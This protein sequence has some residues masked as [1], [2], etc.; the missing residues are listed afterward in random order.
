MLIMKLN[1]EGKGESISQGKKNGEHLHK[2]VSRHLINT[3]NVHLEH[4]HQ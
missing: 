4:A 2:P 1:I 3:Q